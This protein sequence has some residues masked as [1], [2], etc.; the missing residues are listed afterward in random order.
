MGFGHRSKYYVLWAADKINEMVLEVAR[1]VERQWF[2]LER[3]SVVGWWGHEAQM[4][5]QKLQEAT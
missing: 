3:G 1:Q 2:A 4:A 5:K